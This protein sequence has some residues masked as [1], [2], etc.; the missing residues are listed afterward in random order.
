M[1]EN[2]GK[3]DLSGYAAYITAVQEDLG[4]LSLASFITAISK[5]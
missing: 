1:E 2:G 4:L 5:S 3:I